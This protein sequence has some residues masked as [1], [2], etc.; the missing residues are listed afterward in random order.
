V[1]KIGSTETLPKDF[2]IFIPA[3]VEFPVEIS[4]AGNAFTKTASA[5]RMMSLNDNLYLYQYWAS[6]DGK[7]WVQAHELFDLEV[8]GGLAITGGQ[9]EFK[10][11]NAE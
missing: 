10:L 11:D 3:N 9:A 2:I 1:F 7:S 5:D 4:I 8:S 6:R